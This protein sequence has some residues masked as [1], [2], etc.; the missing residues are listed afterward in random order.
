MDIA[1][2]GYKVDSSGLAAA[3]KDLDQNA[4][5]ADRAGGSSER[6]GRYFQSMAQTVERTSGALSTRLGGALDKIDASTGAVV[7]EL[8]ALNRVQTEMLAYLTSLGA[9][10]NS[11]AQDLQG[12]G[13]AGNTAATGAQAAASASQALEK[14]LAEQEAR[15]QSVA[16]KAM[17]WSQANQQANLSD[18]ALAEA[19]QLAASGIDVQALAMSRAGTEQERMAVRA[20]ALQEAEARATNQAREAAAAAERQAVDL[21]QLLGAIDP[22]IAKLNKLAEMEERL[23]RAGD[24]GMLKP[25]QLQQ[26]QGQID[27]M[28]AK[29]LSASRGVEDLGGSFGRL[30]LKTQ[31]SQ[32]NLAQL[33]SYL[34]SGNFGMAGNQVMQLGNSTGATSA[35]LSGLGEAAGAASAGM[36]GLAAGA[37]GALAV[38]GLALVAYRQGQDELYGYQK[39]MLLT[40]QSADVTGGQFNALVGEIDRLVG[41]SRGQAVGALTAVASSGRLAGENI[42]MISAAA[43]RMQA[44]TGQ[45]VSKTVSAF[46]EIARSPVEGLLKLN[47]A[48]GFLTRAQVQRIVTLQ[49]EGHEQA[50]VTEALALY[51]EH[52]QDVGTRSE[53][54]MPAMT[55]WWRDFKGEISDTWG[56][57]VIL[58]GHIDTLASKLGSLPGGKYLGAAVYSALPS[59][60]LG[61]LNGAL[62]N[63][64]PAPIYD[65]EEES[66]VATQKKLVS[67][68]AAALVDQAKGEKVASDALNERISGL[69]R[70]SAKQAAYNKILALYN[71]LAENDP[72]HFDGSMGR[73]VAKANADIDKQ[74]NQ[75]LGLNKQNTDD[76]SAQSFI[77][78]VQ[79]QITANEQLAASGDKVSASDR[80][81]IQ[82]KQLLAD[83]TNT[84]TA[85]TRKLLEA[86]IPTLQTTDAQAQAEV[87]R[88]RGLQATA[89]LTERLAQLEKQRQEQ[90]DIDLMGIS[91]GA[92]AT[93]MLQ[94]QLNIQRDYLQEQEKLNKDF[95]ADRRQLSGEALE[96]RKR[97]YDEDTEYLKQSLDRSLQI[98]TNY[99]QQR[100][101]L[102]GTWSTGFSRAWEDYV[103]AARDASSR[104]AGFLS[105]SLRAGEDD[106]VQF[107]KT[108]KVSFSSLIDSMISDL[109]RYAYQQSIVGLFGG[110]GTGG[111]TGTLASLFSSNSSFSGSSISF[112]GGR[113]GGGDTRFGS[114][115]QVGEG[116]KPEL[117]QQNGKTYLIPGDSG[118]VIPAAAASGG[119]GYGSPQINISVSGNA[120]VESA[121]ATPNNSGGFDVSVILKQ[122]KAAVADDIASGTGSVTSALKGRYGLRPNV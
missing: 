55:R 92:D 26:Y 65:P 12:L 108:G 27:A 42:E 70:A 46:E 24:L 62:G 80:L 99:Q 36:I 119:A 100:K 8:Q 114:F 49:Q 20:R 11:A 86:L 102:L 61:Q 28:R 73:L 103:F 96:I 111:W 104:A 41:V 63:G 6:L 78:S 115:Y 52:L 116:G 9:K 64:L 44:S 29:V 118:R 5:A 40:G 89:Q 16:Q 98:E 57:V 59:Q 60:M 76:N 74:W 58:S 3:T 50:A 54:L 106:F 10:A 107:V 71:G 2:L 33:V 101:A 13:A 7:S 17:A 35:A 38:L 66:K 19:A 23:E 82:A 83:K 67:D 95:N 37:G 75:R 94:R 113:A 97:Q 117:Y 31:E 4:A 109:A 53:Q 21:Q 85:A 84:M 110:G 88:Q 93:Q 77:A 39:A 68:T 15:Y 48:E 112:G 18:R 47:E 120:E 122:I 79:R 14:Q 56:Q 87:Q 34:A 69:D 121:T 90:A 30:N 105:D 81:V 72:R 91:R 51:A 32:R 1:E 43:A 25:A 45:A 22:T